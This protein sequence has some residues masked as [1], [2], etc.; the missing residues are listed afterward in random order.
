MG[1]DLLVF[2]FCPQNLGRLGVA[3]GSFRR[4]ILSRDG[5]EPIVFRS[6]VRVRVRT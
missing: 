6:G 3:R 2:L 5:G 4:L 1:S